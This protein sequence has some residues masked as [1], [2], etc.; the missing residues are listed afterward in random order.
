MGSKFSPAPDSLETTDRVRSFDLDGRLRE[1]LLIE[2][3]EKRF[4]P[5]R[6]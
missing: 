6:Y 5:Q 4:D 2:K 3:N 1:F